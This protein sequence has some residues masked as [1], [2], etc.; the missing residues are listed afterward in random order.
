M[1]AWRMAP[2]EATPTPYGFLHATQPDL[3][4][5]HTLCL[6]WVDFID[7]TIGGVACM[8]QGVLQRM[9]CVPVIIRSW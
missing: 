3:W 9:L 5:P 1:K 2:Y 6:E 8:G 7:V 4:Y